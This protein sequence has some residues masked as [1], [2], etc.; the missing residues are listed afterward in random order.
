MY[1]A[2]ERL[3][4]VSGKYSIGGADS[5][6][7]NTLGPALGLDRHG[8]C[9][10]DNSIARKDAYFGNQADFQM[11]RWQALQKTA[12][13]HSNLFSQATFT[14]EKK[15]SYDDSRATNPTFNAGPK[16]FII[17]MGERVF[18]YKTM[19]NGTEPGKLSPKVSMS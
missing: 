1:Q 12:S 10:V 19:I 3:L 4:Q 6:V 17:A 8:E 14:D 7:P 11:S 13:A 9:E 15:R 16:W 18:V 5:R 2:D